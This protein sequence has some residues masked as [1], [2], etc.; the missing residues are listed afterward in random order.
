MK[1]HLK[2]MVFEG[3]EREDDNDDD[4]DDDN[5]DDTNS[6][7]LQPVTKMLRYSHEKTTSLASNR[8]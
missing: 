3:E 5:V 7:E 2:E 8:C 6:L 4:D 1:N